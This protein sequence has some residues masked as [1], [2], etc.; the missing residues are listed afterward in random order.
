LLFL[1]NW[2]RPDITHVVARLATQMTHRNVSVEETIIKVW[3]YIWQTKNKYL[4]FGGGKSDGLSITSYSDA[5]FHREKKDRKS[6]SRMAVTVTRDLVMWATR[7]QTTIAL[8]TLETELG[9]LVEIIKETIWLRQLVNEV[10]G[11][12]EE[13]QKNMANRKRRKSGGDPIVRTTIYI[14]NQPLLDTINTV[15]ITKHSKHIVTK[16]MWAREFQKKSIL[17]IE[18]ID[19]SDNSAD[20]L[21]KPQ[22][23]KATKAWREH[24]MVSKE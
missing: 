7:K 16:I 14:D 21:T 15:K 24:F 9:A 4:K 8:S 3:A 22:S 11:L 17:Q 2:I 10:V 5:D 18:K 23:E 19:T 13:G 1:S 12:D 20:Y 6:T